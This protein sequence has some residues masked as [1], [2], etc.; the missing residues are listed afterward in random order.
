MSSA[1]T[2]EALPHLRSADIA[3]AA[4]AMD[5][6]A[7]FRGGGKMHEPHRLVGRAAAG[8]RNPGDRHRELGR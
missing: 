4:L 6:S 2:T 5:H 1:S 7:A 8:T 3:E